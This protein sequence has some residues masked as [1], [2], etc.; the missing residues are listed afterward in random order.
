MKKSLTFITAV[1]IL[2]ACNSQEKLT[3]ET[4]LKTLKEHQDDAKVSTYSILLLIHLTLE[5]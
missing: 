5:E 3:R 1:L 2:L 4:A